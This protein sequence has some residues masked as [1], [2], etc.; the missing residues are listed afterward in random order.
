MF[1]VVGGTEED[2]AQHNQS[3]SQKKQP[4]ISG[5]LSKFHLRLKQSVT[6]QSSLSEFLSDSSEYSHGLRNFSFNN[7]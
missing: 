4:V 6:N 2:E 5:K 3:I 1:P 7:L